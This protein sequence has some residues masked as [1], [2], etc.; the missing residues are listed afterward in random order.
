M[1]A[2][3]SHVDA[4]SQAQLEDLRYHWSERYVIDH[5]PATSH[6]AARYRTAAIGDVLSAATSTE[7]RQAIRVDYP[8]RRLAEQAALARLVERSSI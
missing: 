3:V 4:D 8:E 6:W 7:L 1:K 2:T 5:D